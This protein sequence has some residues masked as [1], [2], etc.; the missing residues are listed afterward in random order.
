[1]AKDKLKINLV[2]GQEQNQKNIFIFLQTLNNI[3]FI[4]QDLNKCSFE[5]KTNFLFVIDNKGTYNEIKTILSNNPKLNNDK[6][7]F[8]VHKS[9]NLSGLFNFNFIEVPE[10]INKIEKQIYDFFYDGNLS[11]KNL[12][13]KSN[14]V[15]VSTPTNNEIILTEI[16]SKIL[17]LLFDNNAISKVK[18]SFLALGQ[19]KEVESKSLESH[20]SRLRKKISSIN[21]DVRIISDKGKIVKIL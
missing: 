9:L 16:E 4:L 1:M 13:L 6:I 15:L 3:S 7:L 20:L 14:D 21:N 11:Y 2:V 17:R 18:M 12:H 10:E 8:I 5:H 19:N